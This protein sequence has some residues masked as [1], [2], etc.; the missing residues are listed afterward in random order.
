MRWVKALSRYLISSRSSLTWYSSIFKWWYQLIRHLPPIEFHC[1]WDHSHH[2]ILKFDP[3]F[4]FIHLQMEFGAHTLGIW[5]TYEYY[6]F[7]KWQL[8]TP[9]GND[10]MIVFLFCCICYFTWDFHLNRSSSKS[11]K[12]LAQ[13]LG[14][15]RWAVRQV[16]IR[17]RLAVFI[18]LRHPPRGLTSQILK[19]R[20]RL[21]VFNLWR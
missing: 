16:E 13:M 14:R 21:E 4:S 10:F 11:T 2:E 17:Y 8:Q 1:I 12:I 15:N 7:T 18:H 5:S 20:E 3:D 9:T 6:N 19:L